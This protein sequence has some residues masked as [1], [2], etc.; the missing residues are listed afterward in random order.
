MGEWYILISKL[1]SLL[2]PTMAGL[3]RSVD[4]PVLTALLLGLLGSTAPCQLSTNAGA[5]GLVAQKV[6]NK[7][8]TLSAAVAFTLGKVLVYFLLGSVTILLGVRLNQTAIPVVKTVRLALGPLMLVL[9]LY[10]LGW[11]KFN[12]SLGQ[13][14]E[15]RFSRLIPKSGNLREFWLGVIFSFAFCPTLFWLFFGM[16]IP[17][18][19]S[20]RGGILLPGIFALGTAIPLLVLSVLL[21]Y[22]AGKAGTYLRSFHK[23]NRLA[24]KF[25]GVLFLLAGINDIIAYWLI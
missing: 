24:Q 21:A 6:E 5:L 13:S 7:K 12:V 4:I 20:T 22:G 23:V 18:G 17:L 14:I 19:L 25:G 10:L 11:L 8:A 1:N 9:G 2:S 15:H 3:S 16:V